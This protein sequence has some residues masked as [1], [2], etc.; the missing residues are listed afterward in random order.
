MLLDVLAVLI[1]WSESSID[2]LQQD[3]HFQLYSDFTD[4]YF[5]E[6]L[7]GDIHQIIGNSD[8][9]YPIDEVMEDI[10]EYPGSLGMSSREKEVDILSCF[11]DLINFIMH[12]TRLNMLPSMDLPVREKEVHKELF[13]IER[14]AIDPLI[15]FV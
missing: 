1:G 13:V 5:S 10:D 6:S 7:T 9:P 12:T 11:I 3:I 14:I 4:A 2:S 15:L 8:F